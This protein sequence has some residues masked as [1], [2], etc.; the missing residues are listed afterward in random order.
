MTDLAKAS[1]HPERLRWRLFSIAQCA[2][3]A[4]AKRAG[5]RREGEVLA[6]ARRTAV[7]AGLDAGRFRQSEASEVGSRVVCELGR[8]S[9]LPYLIDPIRPTHTNREI[10]S[11]P[12]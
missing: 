11:V 6:D 12:Q 5:V 7:G 3:T 2:R 9:H 10:A 4:R 8:L 1:D